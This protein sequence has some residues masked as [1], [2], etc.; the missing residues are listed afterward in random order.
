MGTH[1]NNFADPQ[2]TTRFQHV[3]DAAVAGANKAY[4][5]FT[6]FTPAHVFSVLANTDTAGTSTYTGWNGTATVTTTLGDTFS[7]YRLSGTTTT[8]YGP[9]VLDTVAGGVRW[10]QLGSSGSG[11]TTAEGGIALAQGDVFWAV[12]G[13]DATAV[14]TLC[15]EFG[16]DPRSNLSN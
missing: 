3:F 5:K 8:T 16:I 14:H 1:S 13:T 2:Y 11:A 7:C 12:R 9:F 6:V 15:V 10:I 4:S